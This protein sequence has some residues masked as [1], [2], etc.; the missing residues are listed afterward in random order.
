MR[1]VLPVLV[2]ATGVGLL[3]VQD[4]CCAAANA[5][6]APRFVLLGSRAVRGARVSAPSGRSVAFA[7]RAGRSGVASSVSVYVRASSRASTLRVALYTSAQ[8]RPSQ[9]LTAG[10]VRHP[11]TGAWVRVSVRAATL[12]AGQRYWLALLGTGGRLGYRS[13]TGTSCSGNEAVTAHLRRFPRSWTEARRR[14]DCAPAAF[15]TGEASLG[16]PGG[17]GTPGTSTTGTSS[18]GTSTTTTAGT[19]TTT[20]G[21]STSSTTSTSGSPPTNCF[22]RPSACGYPDASNTG[23]P[24]GTTLTPSASIVAHTGDVI[25]GKDVT[26]SIEVVGNNVTIKNTRVTNQGDTSNAIRV[27]SGV[28]GTLIE[29]ST[30]RGQASSNAIQYGVANSGNGTRGLRLQMYNCSECWSGIGLLQD[31]YAISDGVITGAHYEAVYLPGGTTDPADLEHN[32]LLNPHNQTAG[33]FGDDHAWGPMHNVTIND[34]LVAAGGD[35]GAIVTGCNGDGNTNIVV[36]N[37]RVSFAYNA[38]MP[39]G[40][41]NTATTTWTNNYRDDNLTSLSDVSA[42]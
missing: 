18:T 23:V 20:T 1:F 37:N 35:N 8:D 40:S 3:G 29:D 36:T 19:S 11:H 30:L 27:D 21:S 2:V 14:A 25:S 28:T 32:T 42:C 22:A 41:S 39:R 7:M 10:A 16:P 9:L 6:P 15:V 31:S 24:A 26:G 12:R 17:P 38:A 4:P 33:I 34:N 5:T 13:R